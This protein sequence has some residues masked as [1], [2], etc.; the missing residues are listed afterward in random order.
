M[1]VKYTGNDAD[2]IPGSDVLKNI[3][4]ITEQERLTKFERNAV[5]WR[6]VTLPLG[7]LDIEYF[8]TVH[9]H[10]FQD[11]YIWAGEFRSVPLTKGTSR[12]AQPQYIEQQTKRVLH[13]ISVS[14]SISQNIQ[15]ICAS[16]AHFAVE[17]IAIHPFREGNGRV[18]RACIAQVLSSRGYAVNFSSIPEDVWL[19]ASIDGF[20]GN[21]APMVRIFNEIV[22]VKDHE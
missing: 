2:F 19:T 14:L 8:K 21:E 6:S 3:P 7:N 22:F 10:L 20:N 13:E 18:I 12:F 5:A 17:L 11:V 1:P 9:R 4:G 16:I 15:D